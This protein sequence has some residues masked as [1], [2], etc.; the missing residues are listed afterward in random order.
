VTCEVG[1]KLGSA[2]VAFSGNQTS[3]KANKRR[4]KCDTP[5]APAAFHVLLAESRSAR[6]LIAARRVAGRLHDSR[7]RHCFGD[8]RVNAL[9]PQDQ[10]ALGLSLAMAT[11]AGESRPLSS[12]S[13]WIAAAA[14]SRPPPHSRDGPPSGRRA[15]AGLTG[16]KVRAPSGRDIVKSVFPATTLRAPVTGDWK[17]MRIGSS[18]GTARPCQHEQAPSHSGT[19]VPP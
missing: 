15:R 17:S 16:R 10:V 18:L 13:G 9:Q 8:R 3:G 14:R 4:Q 19:R 1:A 7:R 2:P 11:E 5:P 12:Q 6:R